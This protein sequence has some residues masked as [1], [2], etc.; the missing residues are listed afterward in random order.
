MA[1]AGKLTLAGP[2]TRSAGDEVAVDE[3]STPSVGG[4]IS[5]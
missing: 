3:S 5:R 4:D 1:A 2:G